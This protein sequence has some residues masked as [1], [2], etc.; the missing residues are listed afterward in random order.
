VYHRDRSPEG[1]R[2]WWASS[3]REHSTPDMQVRAERV[4][5]HPHGDDAVVVLRSL[6]AD[7]DDAARRIHDVPGVDRSTSRAATPSWSDAPVVLD[8]AAQGDGRARRRSAM[9]RRMKVAMLLAAASVADRDLDILGGGW[10][11]TRR[12]A[13]HDQACAELEVRLAQPRIPWEG[14]AAK[15]WGGA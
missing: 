6:A 1:A 5:V 11:I 4:G 12:R 3:Q 13:W 2:E 9:L 8:T 10:N 14:I 15:R 7:H